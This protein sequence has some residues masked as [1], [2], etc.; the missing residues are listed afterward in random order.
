M[1]V[2][3]ARK[4][5]GIRTRRTY[6]EQSQASCF[7]AGVCQLSTGV[8]RVKAAEVLRR[9][10]FA[11]SSRVR[12]AVY[13]HRTTTVVYAC[14]CLAL[15]RLFCLVS[16]A[17]TRFYWPCPCSPGRSQSGG[18][19]VF[20]CTP[21]GAPSFS[22]PVVATREAL[23]TLRRHCCGANT[24]FVVRVVGGRE[25]I[26]GL[27]MTADDH[28]VIPARACPQSSDHD[29]RV[30][31]D[32][33]SHSQIRRSSRLPRALPCST[34]QHSTHTGPDRTCSGYNSI[35]CI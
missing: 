13:K 2:A 11:A 25:K 27:T 3:D 5:E 16:F 7:P 14:M 4:S 22:E 1:L 31:G 20:F 9:D 35:I 8:K 29:E 19:A 32:G 15:R 33:V 10:S 18:R 17:R 21:P 23:F 28:C 34:A 26:L 12:E 24:R 6:I 30:R